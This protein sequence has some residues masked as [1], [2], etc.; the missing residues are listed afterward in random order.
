MLEIPKTIFK[1]TDEEKDIINIFL[2]IIDAFSNTKTCNLI[3]C[4]ECP[5]RVFCGELIGANA[6]NLE[7][8]IQK[9]REEA[10]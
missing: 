2:R 4:S 6:D 8:Y 7:H 3:D 10:E 9:M 1:F 5:F